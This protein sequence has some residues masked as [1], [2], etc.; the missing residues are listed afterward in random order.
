MRHDHFPE[1]PAKTQRQA[2]D[3]LERATSDLPLDLHSIVA[4]SVRRGRIRRRHR[5]IRTTVAAAAVVASLGVGG[6]VLAGGIAPMAMDAPSSGAS[7]GAPA[8][9]AVSEEVFP[10]IVA[11]AAGIDDVTERLHGERYD[12]FDGT[13]GTWVRPSV[14]TG[15]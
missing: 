2:L 15:R 13:D 10:L 14:W 11:R 6:N 9:F 4:G 8:I 3:L 1:G 7:E 5:R 12:S